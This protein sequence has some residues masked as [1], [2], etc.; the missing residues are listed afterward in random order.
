[1]DRILQRSHLL[2]KGPVGDTW[3]TFAW[4]YNVWKV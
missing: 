2:R 4:K 1:L 3:A